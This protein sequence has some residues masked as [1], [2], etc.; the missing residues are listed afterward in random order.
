M[1]GAADELLKVLYNVMKGDTILQFHGIGPYDIQYVNRADDPIVQ[2]EKQE[3]RS[4]RA[5]AAP[6]ARGVRGGGSHRRPNAVVT[7][8]TGC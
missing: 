1:I 6:A 7:L 3:Q 2:K 4:P 8:T 5:G